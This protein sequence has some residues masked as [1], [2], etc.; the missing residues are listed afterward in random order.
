LPNKTIK[1]NQ[2][3]WLL[4]YYAPTISFNVKVKIKVLYISLLFFGALLA[5]TFARTSTCC[6][7]V[8]T[9]FGK[10]CFLFFSFFWLV[11]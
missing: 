4:S 11:S 9:I 3:D 8:Q 7:L 6:Y 1:M 10:K 5:Y 2:N